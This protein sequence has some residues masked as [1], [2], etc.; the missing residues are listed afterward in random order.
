[1]TELEKI[2]YTK[3]FI[4]K[5]ANGINPIND[6]AVK[7]DDVINN[8]RVTRCFFYISD[9]L[10]Q[11]IE[12]GGISKKK[13]VKIPFF[14]TAEQLSKFKFSE[15]PI[16][17]SEIAKRLNS[18]TDN[19]NMK[20]ISYNNLAEWLLNLSMLFIDK[21]HDGTTMKLPTELGKSIGISLETREGKHGEYFVTVYDKSAQ[22]FIIDNI[23]SI[24][25]AEN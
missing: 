24:L 6:T 13:N 1:M 15:T 10:R 21:K 11:I 8:V 22:S 5:L 2:K 9:I 18:L 7:D 19:E 14:I 23:D 4:D 25:S 16:P 20:K 17:L 3:I 12:N